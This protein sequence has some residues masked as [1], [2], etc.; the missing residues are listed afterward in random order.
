MTKTGFIPTGSE[1]AREAIIVI[2]G[3]LIAA[4]VLSQ[5]PAVRAYIQKNIGSGAGNVGCD[6]DK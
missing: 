2:G 6:C 5:L 4:V 3:A 1:F